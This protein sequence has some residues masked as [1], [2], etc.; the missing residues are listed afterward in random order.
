MK[1]LPLFLTTLFLLF[2]TSVFAQDETAKG[3]LN[4]EH[5]NLNDEGVFLDGYDPVSYFIQKE[6]LKGKSGITARHKGVVYYFASESN[7][8][9]FLEHPDD[10]IPQY[11]GW[12]A[13][14]MGAK[15]E[16]VEV[17]PETFKIV[18][19]KLYLFYNSFFTN[20][21]T[22]WNKDEPHLLSEADMNWEKQVVE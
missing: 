4:F 13:Y 6:A 12:C 7:K 20:T 21:L 2:S 11:G 5:F 9:M 1:N 17:D 18:D 8:R 15:G 22:L 14:A 19:Q 16:K 10:F 3:A